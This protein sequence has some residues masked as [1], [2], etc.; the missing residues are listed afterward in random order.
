MVLRHF[1]ILLLSLVLPV[2]LLAQNSS[3]DQD[4]AT[5]SPSE[6]GSMAAGP[7]EG[8]P[9]DTGAHGGVPS[10]LPAGIL[11]V[12]NGRSIGQVAVDN[13]A[14][15]VATN[16]QAAE[17]ERILE[18][19]INLELLTQQAEKL[20]LDQLT[21]VA[22]ALQLQY[23]QIMANAYLEKIGEDI[24][25]GDEQMRAEYERQVGNLEQSEYKA[26]HILL[27]TEQDAIAVIGQLEN[28]GDFAALAQQK[29][30]DPAGVNGGD[31]GWFQPGTMVPE[32]QTAVEALEVGGTTPIPIQSEFGWHVIKLIDKRAAIKPDFESV[33][34]GLRNL[35]V[36][37]EL[38]RRIDDLR[39]SA[40]I[41]R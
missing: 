27:E 5:D 33:K 8:G 35:M 26:S 9:T 29:S 2:Q 21:E 10:T 34:E 22:A 18:E 31:L 7:T 36:R 1:V 39:T 14:K 15:Q 13:V 23:T 11:A 28:G 3:A 37:N 4:T 30:L 40:D 6:G 12:V 25:I 16:G 24:Q 19:L 32:F 38:A 17:P 20:E 41:K